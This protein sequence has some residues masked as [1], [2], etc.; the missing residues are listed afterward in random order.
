MHRSVIPW[1]TDARL[2]WPPEVFD[3]G[4]SVLGQLQVVEH[5]SHGAAPVLLRAGG[6]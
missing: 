1:P 6:R 4:W 3:R 5:A 2:R